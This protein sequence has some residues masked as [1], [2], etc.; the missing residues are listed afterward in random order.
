MIFNSWNAINTLICGS[1]ASGRER[2]ISEAVRFAVYAQ[3]AARQLKR[4]N[5]EHETLALALVSTLSAVRYEVCE[6]VAPRPS[7]I[8]GFHVAISEFLKLPLI[9]KYPQRGT[10]KCH[11][12]S[13]DFE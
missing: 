11:R 6:D 4:V 13:R 5:W 2:E 1:T 9:F 3:I 10:V 12:I 7:L 8:A